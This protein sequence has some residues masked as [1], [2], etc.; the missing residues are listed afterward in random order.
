MSD[1]FSAQDV[2]NYFLSLKDE[3]SGDLISNLKLQKLIYY[4]QG[5]HLALMHSPLFSES[6]VAW[7]HGPVVD[8]LYHKYKEHGAGDIPKPTDYEI[9]II[10]EGTQDLL[11]EVW[12]VFGQFSGWKLTN[13]THEEAPWKEAFEKCQGSE[14]SHESLKEYFSTQLI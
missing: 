3:D 6:L 9:E 8:S 13:M 2:A 10:D 1:T 12:I 14:I 7:E 5:L 11:D 4:A